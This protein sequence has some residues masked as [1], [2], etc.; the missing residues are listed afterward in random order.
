[1]AAKDLEGP[2]NKTISKTMAVAPSILKAR[3]P[4]SLPSCLHHHS[5]T[6]LYSH[7]RRRD[8]TAPGVNGLAAYSEATSPTGVPY[9]KRYVPYNFDSGTSMASPHVSGM[10]GL[11]KR[12][13][14]AA[15][16]PAISKAMQA[17]NKKESMLNA[18]LVKATPFGY[19]AGR[20]HANR[21]TD[22]GLV[23][24]IGIKD[25][26]RFL[27]AI[28]YDRFCCS[29]HQQDIQLSLRDAQDT[30]SRTVKNVGG[31]PATCTVRVRSSPGIFVSVEPKSLELGAI[32]EERKFQ[33]AAQ[34]QRGAKDGY[35]LGLLVWSDGRHHVRST[36]LVK[37]GIS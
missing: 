13:H 18:S 28:D 9:D 37:V 19:G 10:V 12:A 14:P 27:C 15:I 1:M 6:P 16:K 2:L 31:A 29:H 20:V 4:G 5:S 22:P 11:F 33:V 35:A 8:I 30:I 24:D 25:Y 7:C 34:V 36:I 26:L 3:P 32:G 21:V 17:D 23:Y